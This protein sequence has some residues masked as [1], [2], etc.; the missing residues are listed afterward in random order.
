MESTT[1]VPID[2][3]SAELTLEQKHELQKLINEFGD[4]FAVDKT[5]F[6]FTDLVQ[7]RI[8][9][10]DH[11]PIKSKPCRVPFS[12]RPI[13]E[14]QIKTM[15]EKNIIQPSTSPWSSKVVLV[16]KKDGS[17]RFCID[18]RKLNKITKKEMYP[19]PQIDETLD[20]LGQA[21]YF[22]TLDLAAG[23]WQIGVAP[24]DIEKT[25]FTTISGH[26][27]FMRMPFG[28]CNAVPRYQQLMDFLLAG[29][30]WEICLCY[31]DDI[32]IYSRTFTDHLS[33]LRTVFERL[34]AAGLKVRLTKCTFCRLEVPYLGH[35]ISKDGIKADPSKIAVVRDYPVPTTVKEVREFIGFTSYYRKFI[36]NFA[37]IA[38]PLHKLT[39][40]YARFVWSQQCQEAF[41]LLRESLISAPILCY[42]DFS[43][44]FI[45]YTDASD[46]GIGAVL[47]Q[48]DNQSLER[49]NCFASRVL[50]KSERGYAPVEREALAIVYAV[51]EFRPYLYGNEFTVITDHN[52]LPITLATVS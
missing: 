27:E 28:L 51:K 15:L 39:T 46:V 3:S 33:N 12:Q 50:S 34:R 4:I 2:L 44:P 47:A 9:V 52:P 40:K 35:I 21:Q 30:Q 1:T 17:W 7:H 22:S 8:D 36:K 29:L 43:L 14:E 45:L 16:A 26:F 49:T 42:P 32:I 13:I 41:D 48:K 20:A 24:E 31:L 10:G 23:Y 19:L 11:S 38:A 18:F 37:S 5:D 6:R 25:A